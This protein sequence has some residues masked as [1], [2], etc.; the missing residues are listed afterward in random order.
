MSR[1]IEKVEKINLPVIPTR[2]LV[3]FPSV[4]LSFEIERDFS[5]AAVNAAK[6]SD[7]YVL[8]LC[9][10]SIDCEVPT[11]ADL[12]DVGTVCR[13]KQTHNAPGGITRV[14][15]EGVCRATTL[16]FTSVD[17]CMYADVMT[18]TVSI[19]NEQ[20]DVRAQALM[21]E[22][23]TSLEVM[24]GFA[25]ADSDDILMAAKSIKN[26]GQLADF[27]ASS[28]LVKF[29]DKQEVL[30]AFEPLERLESLLVIMQTETKL[31]G[32][33]MSIH[34]K[35]REAIDENQRDYYLREQLKV[36]QTEL[37]GDGDDEIEEYY[38]K[39]NAA[40]LPK[41]ITDKL[42]KEVGR[43]AKS[44]FGSPE[45]AVLRNYLDICLEIPFTTL[46]EDTVDVAKA[47]KILDDDHD[48]LEK[49]KDRILEYL[50]VKQL[51]PDLGN[52]IICLV[53]PPGT[54]KTSLGA[55]V[56]RAMNRKFVRVSLGGI[57]DEAEIRGHRKTYVAAMPGRIV[58]ALTQAG[59]MNPVM[60]LD[61]V[62]K[63]CSD[64]KGDP[65]SALL[66]VLDGEQNKTFRDHFVEM[67]CDLSKVMFIA[68]ANTLDTIPRPLLDRMEIIE[69]SSYTKNEKAAIA[70]NHLIP[71]QLKR[72]GLT[73]RA[74]RIS[75]QVI[76]EII[77]GY[78]RE[79]GVRNLEREIA[80]LCRKVA[81]TM[82]ETG[83]K[84]VSV[85][86]QN[87]HTFLG[88]RKFLD[89]ERAT[90]NEIGVVNGLA[91]TS[92]GGDVL[93]VE[94]NV[95]DGTGKL[96]LTGTLGDVMKESAKIAVSYIRAHA[97]ELGIPSDFYKTKDIHIHVPEGATP[98]DG[99]SA[100]VTMLSSLVSTLS[101]TPVRCDTAMTGELTLTGRVL[102]IG[103]LKEKTT[104]A[105]NAGIKRVII[106]NDNVR[107][108]DEIDP[109][110]RQNLLFI[111]CKR[112]EQVLSEILVKDTGASPRMT[113]EARVD[114]TVPTIP[115]DSP[116]HKSNACVNMKENNN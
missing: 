101:G 107:D 15:A 74:L 57:R 32:L 102:P 91:Y 7:M 10:K 103:G 58:T 26:P 106:P 109:I 42:L 66:E 34:K 25:S 95:M 108:L 29:E 97:E 83:K 30:S 71:K 99:P 33:E 23:I 86:A 37:N 59:S 63:L 19:E 115:T 38:D 14:I 27:I 2:G 80:S 94:S 36:I 28:A 87:L 45:A 44:P 5:V 43:L 47:K 55:S 104:A 4:P 11:P 3:A 89:E 76:E 16:S 12:Y 18:K 105:W 40:N 70:E 56:A 112:C 52:Q 53:G 96:E 6:D 110:V 8:L 35:V 84:S 77:D 48:G 85:T 65:S 90:Q 22:A 75:R 82:I 73:K 46:T 92:V 61:E 1:Y 50:A 69:L 113:P 51:N 114:N 13:I 78:T 60:L 81:R 41:E 98:K 100:G 17:R 20:S 111:P 116:C 64:M 54:G 21:R 9:Q 68:T 72:H 31:L 39:I 93:K 62:D 79:S 67:P 88:P 24:M 49:P